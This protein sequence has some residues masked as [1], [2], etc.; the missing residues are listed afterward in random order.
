[1]LGSIIQSFQRA[2]ELAVSMVSCLFFSFA[3]FLS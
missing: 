2:Q 3:D 1:M